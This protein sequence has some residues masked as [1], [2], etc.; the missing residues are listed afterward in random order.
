MTDTKKD[1][2]KSL[3]TKIQELK[4]PENKEELKKDVVT[5]SLPPTQTEVHKSSDEVVNHSGEGAPSQ[6]GADVK[7]SDE[8]VQN[9]PSTVIGEVVEQENKSLTREEFM[10]KVADILKRYTSDSQSYN[11]SLAELDK[12]VPSDKHRL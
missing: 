4:K 7:P 10:S 11:K 9:N 6:L 1:E 2:S 12:L 3:D 8:P 5:A